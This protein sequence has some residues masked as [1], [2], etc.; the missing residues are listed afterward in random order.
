MGLD[1]YLTHK[2]YVQNW[3]HDPVKSVVTLSINGKDIPLHDVT[4]IYEQVGYWRKSN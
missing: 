4:Y 1:M 2:R 3:N